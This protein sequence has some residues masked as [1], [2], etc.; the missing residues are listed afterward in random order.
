M[1]EL[2]V[3]ASV[4]ENL[5][6]AIKSG[7]QYTTLQLVCLGID[8]A[9]LMLAAAEGM[10]QLVWCVLMQVLFSVKYATQFRMLTTKLMD[11]RKFLSA[12]GDNVRTSFL[13]G[14]I[15]R[16]HGKMIRF[17]IHLDR[18]SVSA[19]IVLFVLFNIPFNNYLISSLILGRKMAV[20]LIFYAA[21]QSV[22]CLAANWSALR[23][24]IAILSLTKPMSSIQCALKSASHWHCNSIKYK[25]LILYEQLHARSEDRCTLG[26]TAGP[27]GMI[28][29]NASFQVR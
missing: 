9:M 22:C 8:R 13:V 2:V 25:T 4:L 20:S 26:F 12:I 27:L 29:R 18:C 1:P 24:N 17:I 7:E 10:N 14:Q 19:Q 21:V 11:C 23:L 6:F 3:I 16:L 28:N 15:Y 5:K